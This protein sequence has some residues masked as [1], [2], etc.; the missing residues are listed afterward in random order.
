MCLRLGSRLWSKVLSEEGQAHHLQF[1]LQRLLNE[2]W[3]RVGRAG[4]WSWGAAGRSVPGPTSHW[5]DPE[6]EGECH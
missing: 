1:P 5:G 3:V 2:G 6:A 4:E